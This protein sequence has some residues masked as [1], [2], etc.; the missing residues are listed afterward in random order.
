ME[1]YVFVRQNTVSQYIST[2][3]IID[4]FLETE[5][6]PGAQVEKLWWEKLGLSLVG[7]REDVEAGGAL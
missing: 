4:L 2:R 3:P 5:K 6:R 1:L 7:A